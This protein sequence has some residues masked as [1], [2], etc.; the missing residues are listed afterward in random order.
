[1]K[2]MK[3]EEKETKGIIEAL[4]FAWG[5]PLA[6]SEI[7]RV[8]EMTPGQVKKII[9]EMAED[10]NEEGRGLVIRFYDQSAQLTTRA[11]HFPALSRL[12]AETRKDRLTNSSLETLAII[13]YEG[14]VT[15]IDVDNLRGVTSS[16]SID[17][18]MKKGLVEEA[19]RLDQPGRPI[20]YRTTLKFLEKFNIA[21][22]DDLPSFEAVKEAIHEMEEGKSDAD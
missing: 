10:F 2:E 12:F 22:L 4:L 17:T 16:S 15:R 5:D 14:P 19:G 7:G 6:F 18:L 13:A 11:D 8:L 21:S 3:M 1:M 9:E 20:L